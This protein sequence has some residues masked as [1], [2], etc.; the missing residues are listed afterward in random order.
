MQIFIYLCVLRKPKGV[1]DKNKNE[2]LH[3]EHID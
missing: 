3:S 1:I 2:Q